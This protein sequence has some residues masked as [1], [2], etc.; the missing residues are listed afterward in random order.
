MYRRNFDEMEKLGLIGEN[1][2]P[3]IEDLNAHLNK[4]T[5]WNVKV[6]SSILSHREFLNT[7]AHR[8]FVST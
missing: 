3:Q 2:I 1:F 4:K 5:N 7:I 8:T 6:I